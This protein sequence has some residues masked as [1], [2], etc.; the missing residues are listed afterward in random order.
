MS[1][2]SAPAAVRRVSSVLCVFV[3]SRVHCMCRERGCLCY[4]AV[5]SFS[6]FFICL[7][8]GFASATAIWDLFVFSRV[9]CESL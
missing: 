6:F 3:L 5:V 4:L 7:C 2:R 9:C 1:S 8:L